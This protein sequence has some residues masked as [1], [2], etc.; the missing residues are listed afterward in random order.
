[1][2]ETTLAFFPHAAADDDEGAFSVFLFVIFRAN[3]LLGLILLTIGFVNAWFF[4][5]IATAFDDILS[6]E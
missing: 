3:L 6:T 2:Y 1:M 5:R 4:R